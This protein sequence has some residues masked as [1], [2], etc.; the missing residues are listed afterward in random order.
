MIK[1]GT[2]RAMILKTDTIMNMAYQTAIMTKDFNSK[3]FSK[4]KPLRSERFIFFTFLIDYN[5]P[6]CFINFSEFALTGDGGSMLNDFLKLIIAFFLS[7]FV[8]FFLA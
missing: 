2:T 1:V 4:N 8:A 5:A 7:P 3:L 6:S